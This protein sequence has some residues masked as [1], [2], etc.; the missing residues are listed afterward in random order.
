MEAP[1]N[2]TPLVQV[3]VLIPQR[4]FFNIKAKFLWKTKSFSKVLPSSIGRHRTKKSSSTRREARRLA[5]GTEVE[6]AP[7][8][9]LGIGF[10]R[11]TPTRT[12]TETV[13]CMT[14]RANSQSTHHLPLLGRCSTSMA[15]TTSWK[16]GRDVHSRE[17]VGVESTR[18]R[19][20][21]N[22]QS[23]SMT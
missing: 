14:T 2:L 12:P 7:S 22:T 1:G 8:S 21:M 17:G 16:G 9:R 11:E 18:R 13:S 15:M 5:G 23:S 3:R 4:N 20:A 10:S 6:R 19:R